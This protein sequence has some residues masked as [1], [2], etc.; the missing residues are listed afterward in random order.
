M[1]LPSEKYVH[2]KHHFDCK[3]AI[4]MNGI[5]FMAKVEQFNLVLSRARH[6]SKR[7]AIGWSIVDCNANTLV[8]DACM[9]GLDCG[10][11]SSTITQFEHEAKELFLSCEPV[12]HACDVDQ[13]CEAIENSSI[14]TLTV[15]KEFAHRILGNTWQT[16]LD[17]WNG[18]LHTLPY[19]PVIEKLSCGIEMAYSANRPWLTAV[20]AASFYGVSQPLT[21]LVDEF[22]FLNYL[23]ILTQQSRAI[24]HTPDQHEII[25]HLPEEN[26]LGEPTEIFE[27]YSPRTVRPILQ[28]CANESR[29]SALIFCD[30]PFLSWLITQGLVDEIIHHIRKPEANFSSAPS[31]QPNTLLNLKNWQLNSSDLVGDCSRLSFIKPAGESSH[32]PLQSWLN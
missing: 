24:L 25:E 30:L 31:V 21:N 32:I 18:T 3:E 23:S 26:F 17:G 11:L 27:T 8:Y 1:Y 16:W 12:Y 22:D 10:R 19:N 13:L 2:L 5:L 28:H 14:D 6:L 15:G 20:T 9:P 7:A 4:G 29:C